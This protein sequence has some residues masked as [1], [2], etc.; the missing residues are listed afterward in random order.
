MATR[1]TVTQSFDAPPAAVFALYGDR[2]FIEGRLEQ[3]G[4][5]DPQVVSVDSTPDGLTI[6]T[7]QGIPASALP[8]M[9]S[10]MMKDDPV[11]E[12]TEQWRADGD[13]YVADFSVSVKGAPASLTGTM[14]LRP[15]GAGCELAVVG[16]AAVPIPIFGGKIE[17]VIAEQVRGLLEE[18]Q[19][20]TRQRL[21]S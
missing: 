5:I 10:S 3:S 18:E 2:S 6:V 4:G 13:T 17:Q 1:L 16:E 21:T 14:T 19:D 15:A 7:R 8:S 20:Y 12:R 9:V 11:T